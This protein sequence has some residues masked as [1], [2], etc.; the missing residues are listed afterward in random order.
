MD[1]RNFANL[2][3]QTPEIVC[4]TSGPDHRFEFVNEAHIRALGFDASGRTVRDA[5]PESVEVHGILDD[6]YRT[7]KTAE[8]REIPV[9]VTDR[10]RYFNLTYAARR[11]A[12]DVIDGI[13]IM[14]SEV[15]D[16]VLARRSQDNQRRWL[17]TVLN[18]LPS[19]T[20]FV[21][22]V[23]D[24]ITFQN[25]AAVQ[26]IGEHPGGLP[27]TQVREGK[28][29]RDHPLELSSREGV[30][31]IEAST[32]L[33]PEEFGQPATGLLV[34]KDVTAQKR[35]QRTLERSEE[36]LTLALASSK[37]GFFDWNIVDDDIVFSDQMRA[38]WG[39]VA[40]AHKMTLADVVAIIHPQDRE[41]AKL[42]IDAAMLK[43]LPLQVEYRVVRP[44]GTTVWI[45]ARGKVHYDAEGR[46][47]R[48]FGTSLDVSERAENE[49]TL[50]ALADAM[51]QVV[52]AA[53][54]DG[55][56]DY[57]NQRWTEYSGS[58]DPA[59]WLD[60]VMPGERDNVVASWTASVATGETYEA[61]FHLLRDRDRTYRW[62]LVR[63]NPAF[64][65]AG[66]VTRWFGTCID[67]EDQKRSEELL[68]FLA[69]ASVVLS[70]SLDYQ[71]TLANVT[72]MAVPMVADWASVDM[73]A[74]DGS[75]RRLAVAHVDPSKIR[76]AHELWGR[77]PPKLDDANG[78]GRVIRTGKAE[79][80]T[81]I[82]DALLVETIKDGELLDTVRNL[83]LTSWMS[84]PLT[85]RGKTLGAIT[86]VSAESGRSFSTAELRLAKDLA[87][88]AGAAID[89]AD[90]Y[91]SA[92][93]AR[94]TADDANRLKDDFLATVSHELRTPLNAMLGWTRM[95]RSGR[96]PQ[97]RH[98]RALET[99]ERNAVTQAQLI[100][101]LLDVA[102][103]ISGKLRLDV[104]SVEVVH[105][106]E[107]AVE[108]LKV[109]SDARKIE[110]LTALDPAA[111]QVVGDP[112]RLGQV[113]WNL[114]SNA[115][116]FTPRGGRIHVLAERVDS[117]LRISVRD[118]GKGIAPEF[119]PYVF[120]RF[121]QEDGTSTRAHGGLGLGLAISRNIVELHGGT[122]AVNSKG[123]GQGAT[124][125][126][127]LP[128][129][130]LRSENRATSSR[131]SS[132]V[133]TAIFTPRPELMGLRVLVV[134]D[135]PDARE[136]VAAILEECGAV[137]RMAGSV[138]EALALVE[139][140]LPDLILSDIG[141]P[142]EDGYELIRRVRALPRAAMIP[143]AALTAYARA[144]DRRKA[145]DAGF[146]MHITKPV[147][148]AELI[149]VMAN[150][151]RFAQRAQTPDQ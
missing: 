13:M 38:D 63:A 44:D 35:I 68:R 9:T 30:R 116:K 130:S 96:L 17:E 64:D 81:E 15:T 32:D 51:P 27:L 97:D 57:T 23:T 93:A 119:L 104:Q 73:L 75:I 12:N 142:G 46:A 151:Q 133:G 103:I 146:M 34:L 37:V 29:L 48:F 85:V 39:I 132:S 2:F 95:L 26:L 149:A 84:V 61:E 16:Q 24:D 50:R 127:T 82:S 147:E 66:R 131:L 54:S 98:E 102:R 19:P 110:V 90:L 129:S 138:A 135:E 22:P 14:G 56:L 47:V 91:A 72:R 128:M 45:E 36:Q 115:I 65:E 11:N 33:I 69:D 144:E 112:H 41:R 148:P 49:R 31:A 100:D 107:H 94:Q 43:R 76:L 137:V 79:V 111:G 83:G 42:H 40:S 6:V 4:V 108:A 126:V 118:T 7:G 114:L 105:I 60:F 78:I 59:R 121:K 74:P 150:L 89:N 25:D 140:E 62:H 106:V 113:M 143:A 55:V 70:S 80:L 145:L 109:A 58:S 53:R 101:D 124:F 52:W 18:R 87:L 5:Q 123:E 21:D 141:M 139:E 86:F 10:E 88:R 92:V 134:D 20:L 122:I 136:V 8:L 77:W 1:E 3:R 71:T 67:I 117:S 120:D 28:S 99:I 125:V